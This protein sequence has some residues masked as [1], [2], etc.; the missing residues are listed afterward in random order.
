MGLFTNAWYG[1]NLMGNLYIRR[2]EFGRKGNNKSGQIQEHYSQ[3]TIG[4]TV[5]DMWFRAS[6]DRR[7]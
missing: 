1:Y 6:S 7:D 2:A 4:F 5:R 3:V